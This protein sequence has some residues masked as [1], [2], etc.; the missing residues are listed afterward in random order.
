VGQV[1]RRGLEKLGHTVV[2]AD[3]PSVFDDG[4]KPE[5]DLKWYEPVFGHLGEADD[6]DIVHVHSPNLKKFLAVIPYSDV[7]LVC[8]WHGTDLRYWRKAW[9]VKRYMM[10]HAAMNL[11]STVD[12]AWWLQGVPKR[13]L[14]CPV[15]TELFKPGDKPGEG[16]VV[17]DGGA[18]AYSQHHIPHK[19]MPGYLRMFEFASIHNAMG[20]DDTLYSIIAFECAACGLM[21]EQFPWMT[22]EWVLQNAS[23]PVV[24]I[25]LQKIYQDVMR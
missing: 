20:L 19:D 6:Y 8:H 23:I 4:M 25:Q 2:M 1:L 10:K 22:R 12:L 14:N 5:Y 13:L 18:K 7:P 24:T 16:S 17:F 21:V 11:Y 9:P 15:D 3:N